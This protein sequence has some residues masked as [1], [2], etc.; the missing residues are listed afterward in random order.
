M[1]EEIGNNQHL[2]MSIMS[3]EMMETLV[4]TWT[5][6]GRKVQVLELKVEKMIIL[7]KL[8]M[9]GMTMALEKLLE[10]GRKDCQTLQELGVLS[11]SEESVD[12][13]HLMMTMSTVWS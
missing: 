2:M 6:I 11:H 5:E 9:F 10:I 8:K 1:T 3:G 4:I 12:F 13:A 7:K